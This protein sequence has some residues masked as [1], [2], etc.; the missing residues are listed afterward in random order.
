[1]AA[2]ETWQEGFGKLCLCMSSDMQCPRS[3]D[4]KVA[5]VRAGTSP[6]RSARRQPCSAT[7]PMAWNGLEWLEAAGLA[8]PNGRP[9]LCEGSQGG[10][11]SAARRLRAKTKKPEELASAD[12]LA[13][14]YNANC[15]ATIRSSSEWPGSNSKVSSVSRSTVSETSA[16]SRNS[17]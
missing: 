12:A 7:K 13:Q 15:S 5:S 8:R 4:L 2:R 6:L 3:R 9:S 10:R 14:I 1:M 16:I 17:R 11:M